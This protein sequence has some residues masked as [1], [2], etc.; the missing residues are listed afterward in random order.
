MAPI[1]KQ[2]HFWAGGALSG[3]SIIVTGDPVA[4]IIGATVA[5]F[6]KELLDMSGLGQ[7][8]PVDLFATALGGVAVAAI[9]SFV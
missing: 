3:V 4:G 5:G 8:D 6:A 2:A 7:P 9:A 1:D